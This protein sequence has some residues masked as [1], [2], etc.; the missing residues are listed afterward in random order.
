MTEFLK[1]GNPATSNL[2]YDDSYNFIINDDQDLWI[3]L[4]TSWLW[5]TSQTNRMSGNNNTCVFL[6]S[7]NVNDTLII[8]LLLFHTSHTHHILSL[9]IEHNKKNHGL[10]KFIKILLNNSVWTST[11]FSR[12]F[13]DYRYFRSLEVSALSSM[14]GCPK[15]EDGLPL[16]ETTTHHY[17]DK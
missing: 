2:S 17:F 12:I 11:H 8:R 15:Q 3:L 13:V 10:L 4:K 7:L 9:N 14:A 5:K 6:Q 16:Q 1:S